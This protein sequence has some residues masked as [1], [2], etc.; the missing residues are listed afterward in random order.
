MPDSPRLRCVHCHTTETPLWRTGPDGPRSLCNACGVRFK[1]GKLVLYKDDDGKVTAVQRNDSEPYFLPPPAKKAVKRHLYPSSAVSSPSPPPASPPPPEAPSK[2]ISRKT[3]ADPV[4]ST[5]TV[6]KKPRSR[7]RRVTA[8]QLPGRYVSA[9]LPLDSCPHSWRSPSDSPSSTPSSPAQSPRMSVDHPAAPLPLSDR[10]GDYDNTSRSTSREEDN[11]FTDM[12][13]LGLNASADPTNNTLLSIPVDPSSAEQFS[14]AFS[15]LGRDACLAFDIPDRLGALR[16][17]LLDRTHEI[18]KMYDS[19]VQSIHQ[20]YKY[21]SEHMLESA[22]SSPSSSCSDVRKSSLGSIK[23]FVRAFAQLDT[24]IA[25]RSRSAGLSSSSLAGMVD[26]DDDA[27]V[28]TLHKPS[29]MLMEKTLQS[30]ASEKLHTLLDR[31]SDAAG[32]EEAGLLELLSDDVSSVYL[33]LK[34]HDSTN[35]PFGVN[36]GGDVSCL[37]VVATEA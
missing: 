7:S 18:S 1:K 24:P 5:A 15:G 6:A 19:T 33:G 25:P 12:A 23:R 16:T 37:N 35:I 27:N 13:S 14:F 11:L 22:H 29:L 3:P 34:G 36:Y 17:L 31:L 8:G 26:D 28:T 20:L 21:R 9:N 4:S 32:F 30:A 10:N 2:R